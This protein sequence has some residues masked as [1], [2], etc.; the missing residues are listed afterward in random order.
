MADFPYA[1]YRWTAFDRRHYVPARTDGDFRWRRDLPPTPGGGQSGMH[2][3]ADTRRL[4]GIPGARHT[5]WAVR[6][7]AATVAGL[8]MLATGLAALPAGAA[9]TT[10]YVDRSASCPGL[11]LQAAPYCTIGAAAAAATAGTT[12]RVAA[13]TY[14]ETVTP[15]RSGASGSPIVYDADPGATV[16]GGTNGFT[17]A[18]RSWVTVRGFTVADTVREGILV[19]GSSSVTVSG[20][21]VTSAGDP[22]SGRTAQGIR[23][24][25]TTDSLVQGNTADHN[26]EATPAA[27]PAP[28]RAST[29]APRATR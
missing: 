14:P 1:L 7:A 17:V 24:T 9:G 4:P 11:G 15:A 8:A 28:R 21:R 27:T 25:G 5:R 29:C 20:N 23:L 18:S 6:L 26:S 16:R 2:L 19:S 10:L 22:V 3:H 12:V 13:G